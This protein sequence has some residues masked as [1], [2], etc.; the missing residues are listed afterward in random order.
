MS[1]VGTLLNKDYDDDI[2][3]QC[4]LVMMGRCRRAFYH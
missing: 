2:L 4:S 3:V 1:K